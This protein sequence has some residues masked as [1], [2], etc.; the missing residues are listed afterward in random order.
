MIRVEKALKARGILRNPLS[1]ADLIEEMN[2]I[3]DG[4]KAIPESREKVVNLYFLL[5]G[6]DIL[7]RLATSD[8]SEGLV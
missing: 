5:E 3:M 8:H 6:Q 2:D 4:K 7:T 1:L